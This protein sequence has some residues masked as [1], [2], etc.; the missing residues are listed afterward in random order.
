M[1]LIRSPLIWHLYTAFLSKVYSSNQ[2]LKFL[3]GSVVPYV[4]HKQ[5]D[6]RPGSDANFSWAEPNA[7][8]GRPNLFRLAELI[9][10][11]ILIPAE[12]N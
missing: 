2:P 1:I 8:K 5:R 10:T 12:L 7:N 11:P 3:N 6:L 9:Q 4:Y